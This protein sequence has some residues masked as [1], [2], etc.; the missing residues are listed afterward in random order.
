MVYL[1]AD[2]KLN[3]KIRKAWPKKSYEAC[4]LDILGEGAILSG[5]RQFIFL[6]KNAT[7]S[8]SIP[9]M[10][11][12]YPIQNGFIW[13]VRR[14]KKSKNWL[15]DLFDCYGNLMKNVYT[16]SE[17]FKPSGLQIGPAT[18]EKDV[19][20]SFYSKN[21]REVCLMAQNGHMFV[22]NQSC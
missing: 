9:E 6:E 2:G 7:D 3:G 19:L 15:V 5:G 22:A 8:L 16:F 13:N 12:V 1:Q 10:G 18:I 20:L 4:N 21:K 14:D 17:S 11:L